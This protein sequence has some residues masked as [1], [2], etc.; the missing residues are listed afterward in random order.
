[1]KTYT[2]IK[3]SH[4]ECSNCG[5]FKMVGTQY[6]AMKK[7]WVDVTCLSCSDSKDI[8]VKKL[9][10]VLKALGFKEIKER[11]VIPE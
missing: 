2:V 1:M 8:E 9:N 10:Q 7:N 5:G 3:P 11:Y 6:Y 4:L